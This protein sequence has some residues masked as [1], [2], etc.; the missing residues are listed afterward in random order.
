M[1]A[2][3][4]PDLQTAPRI[5]LSTEWSVLIIPLD[6][7]GRLRMF[8]ESDYAN[9]AVGGVFVGH[10]VPSTR[11]EREPGPAYWSL[12]AYCAARKHHRWPLILQT[13]LSPQRRRIVSSCDGMISVTQYASGSLTE[14]GLPGL[15]RR[16]VLHAQYTLSV[17]LDGMWAGHVL[18]KLRLRWP[19]E[20]AT[21][22]LTRTLHAK[23]VS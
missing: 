5:H 16:T 20:C 22:L 19:C 2:A 15:T 7:R 4:V 9:N 12:Y 23:E 1:S 18:T 13:G 10:G 8:E 6:P 17:I 11:I 14:R 21:M 3:D